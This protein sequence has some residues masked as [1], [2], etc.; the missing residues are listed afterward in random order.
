MSKPITPLDPTFVRRLHAGQVEFAYEHFERSCDDMEDPQ[1]LAVI[2]DNGDR[3]CDNM[4]YYPTECHPEFTR[5]ILVCLQYCRGMKTEDLEKQNQ[6]L[7][8]TG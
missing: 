2:A 5:R 6:L 3:V 8:L 1:G 4:D 7:G